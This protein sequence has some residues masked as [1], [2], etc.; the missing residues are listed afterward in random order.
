MRISMRRERATSWIMAAVLSIA[1][2]ASSTPIVSSANDKVHSATS[3]SILVMK[4]NG[5][6]VVVPRSSYTIRWC[7]QG[8]DT[9]RIEYSV[10]GGSTWLLIRDAVPAVG[11][12]NFHCP[13]PALK[14]FM[15]SAITKNMGSYE[16]NVPDIE[17]SDVLIRVL[18][19]L[20]PSIAD[21]SDKPF[22][23]TQKVSSSWTQQSV[24]ASAG[25]VSV[26]IVD[27]NIVWTCGWGGVVYRTTNGGSSW[28]QGTN[29]PS[30]GT[31]IFGLNADTALVCANLT[32][33]GRIY[34][35]TNGGISW[36]LVFEYTGTS[37]AIQNVHMF[38]AHGGVALGDPVGGLWKILHT[39]NSGLTWDSLS[40]VPQSGW[41]YRD[42]SVWV[43][44][45][46]GWFGTDGGLVYYT[47]DGG[48]T[49]SLSDLG[50]M[51]VFSLEFPNEALG[52][53]S[54]AFRYIYKTTNG[55]SSWSY[56]STVPGTTLAIVAF[57]AG[58]A[59]PTP[60]WWATNMDEIFRST[61]HGTSWT[62]ETLAN[63]YPFNDIAMKY[64]P[65]KGVIVGYAVAAADGVLM[66][67]TELVTSAPDDGEYPLPLSME[68]DQNYPN[69]FNPSTTLSYA[70]PHSSFV[71][72]K[73]YNM[74]GQEVQALVKEQKEA[75]AHH[76][77]FNAE[78]LPSGVYVYRIE[79][80]GHVASR[81]MMLL[82]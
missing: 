3:V 35:T 5:G 53:A 62:Y 68:L 19:R 13:E 79:S 34:R 60:R 66:K 75:G 18:D 31:G 64:I 63:G 71:V 38:D 49:W 61:N 41:G 82:K 39:T 73:V 27:D 37:A 50:S 54:T 12:D 40:Q 11:G 28:I 72:L 7:A 46:K 6:Q 47:A 58:V 32:N 25:L 8:I 9:V 30:D 24:G 15:S 17:S 51:D 59:V 23:V 16:W 76:V 26:S 2:L 43:S 29:V 10:D 52:M 20:Q 48:L 14:Q 67:Y 21:V 4:P 77:Q 78:G 69:P 1:L 81:K 55:G 22:S 74:L 70:L 42:A 65:D 80:E 44:Q 56:V 33:N 45:S 36:S 57:I